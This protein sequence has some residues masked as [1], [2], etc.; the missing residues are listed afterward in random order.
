MITVQTNKILR[1]GLFT[2]AIEEVACPICDLSPAAK[3]IYRRDNG[4]CIWQCP[5]CEIMYASPRFT[6]EAL[7]AIY[8]TPDFFKAEELK[9][10]ANFS[11]DTWQASGDET[12]I[13]SALKAA[14]IKKYLAQGDRILDVGCG[15]GLF[16]LEGRHQGF[17]TEGV[18]P[19]R[20]LSD[21]ASTR[22]GID[23]HNVLIEDFTPGYRFNGVGLW[24]V[25]EHV[26][27]PL[28]ILKRCFDLT[29]DNGYIFVSVPNFAGLSDR[30]QTLLHRIKLRRCGFKHF[31]FPWHVY[32]YN[33]RSLGMLLAKAGYT[34]LTFETWSHNVRSGQANPLSRVTDSLIRK[35]C[36][37]SNVSCVARKI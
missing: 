4:V 7:L 20:M 29:E 11:H 15:I 33:R 9:K 37:A 12:Y 35:H 26:Y 16:V 31:G 32:S 10:I 18:E 13:V 36:L 22:I 25:L 2:G 14:N 24:D 3:L 1:D 6:E 19:S 17:R 5:A 30:L 23:I 21:I 28:R 34:P 8:E 27:D